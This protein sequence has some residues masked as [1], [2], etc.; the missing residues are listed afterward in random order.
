MFR[1]LAFPQADNETLIQ[2]NQSFARRFGGSD[3][4]APTGVVNAFVARNLADLI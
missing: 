2:V 4:C 3:D 1:Q